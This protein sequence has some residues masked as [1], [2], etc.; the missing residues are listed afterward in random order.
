[1]LHYVTSDVTTAIL[2]RSAQPFYALFCS[3]L[4]CTLGVA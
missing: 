2:F 3:S 1:M 4:L